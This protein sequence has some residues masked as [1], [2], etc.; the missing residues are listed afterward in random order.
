MPSAGLE[1]QSARTQIALPRHPRTRLV[2]ATGRGAERY[3][4]FTT[5]AGASALTRGPDLWRNAY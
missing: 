2:A 4:A 5:D 1:T 3:T